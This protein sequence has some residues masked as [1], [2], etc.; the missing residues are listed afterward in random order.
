MLSF[1]LSIFN[2]LHPG[3]AKIVLRLGQ[4]TVVCELIYLK[5]SLLSWFVNLCIFFSVFGL[6]FFIKRR[7]KN[8]LRTNY[9][10]FNNFSETLIASNHPHALTGDCWIIVKI[11]GRGQ[12]RRERT[13]NELFLYV[14]SLKVQHLGFVYL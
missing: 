8:N 2:Q 1:E 14:I 10:H 3:F 7:R 12:K 11:F 5:H 6:K 9:G 4:N 13:R